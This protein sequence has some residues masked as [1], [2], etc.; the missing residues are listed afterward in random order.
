MMGGYGGGVGGF[1][2]GCFGGYGGGC[3]GGGGNSDM[4]PGDWTCPNCQ[5]HVFAKNDA[6]RKCGTPK[7]AS[8]QSF[9]GQAGG[10][11]GGANKQAPKPGDWYCPNCQDLQFARNS[12][13]RLCQPPRPDDDG[14]TRARS[15]SPRR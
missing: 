12:V 8:A 3:G 2:G 9:G 11:G 10:G 4:R 15:R 13:C 7:P 1:G 5:D 6:C 14:E